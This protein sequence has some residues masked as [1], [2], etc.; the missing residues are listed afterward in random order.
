MVDYN[1]ALRTVTLKLTDITPTLEQIRR[2]QDA[3]DQRAEY[4]LV[5]DELMDSPAFSRRMIRFWRDT[6]K[7]GGGDLDSAPVFAAQV[8]VENRSFSE[9]LT[10]TSGNCPSYDGELEEFVPGDCENNA[11][12]KRAFSPIPV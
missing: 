6:F 10:A 7:Q 5:V 11:P 2:V 9:V 12:C 3:D 8:M 4:E 1:E